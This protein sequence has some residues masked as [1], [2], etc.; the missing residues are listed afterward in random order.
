MK[1]TVVAISLALVLCAPISAFAAVKAGGTCTKL[2]STT[3]IG[4]IKF[5]C[6]KSGKRLVWNKGVRVLV[7]SA[8]PT[9]QN[10]QLP[11]PQST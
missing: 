9:P 11:S 3:T 2:N 7:P 4:G 1:R 6:V 10:S 5:T 8:K